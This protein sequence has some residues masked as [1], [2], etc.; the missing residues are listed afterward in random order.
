MTTSVTNHPLPLAMRE[1]KINQTSIVHSTSSSLLHHTILFL[2]RRKEKGEFSFLQ[3][4][5]HL[6]LL[7][8]P[9]YPNEYRTAFSHSY[10]TIVQDQP[11]V[12]LRLVFDNYCKS[13]SSINY[14]A[15]RGIWK[16]PREVTPGMF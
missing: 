1:F 8:S 13:I 10:R 6:H 9:S 14:V 12:S 11:Y 3:M 15:A 5:I 16:S 7:F 4:N 2:W